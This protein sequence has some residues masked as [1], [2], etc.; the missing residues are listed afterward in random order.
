[1][2]QLFIVGAKLLGL[3]CFLWALMMIVQMLA[4]SSMSRENNLISTLLYGLG[5]LIYFVIIAWFGFILMKRTNW[6][7]DKAGLDKDD[8]F[9]SWPQERKLLYV[10]IVI[11]GLYVLTQGIPGLAKGLI[12]NIYYTDFYGQRNNF[13]FVSISTDVVRIAVGVILV[14]MADKIIELI[15]KV[16]K[17]LVKDSNRPKQNVPKEEI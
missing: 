7:A 3:I 6:V 13:Y 1:M 4:Y 9:P 2:R 12:T 15:D 14:I 10:G 5:S 11:L 17:K 16:Q 8:A